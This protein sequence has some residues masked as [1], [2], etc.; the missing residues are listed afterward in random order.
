MAGFTQEEYSFQILG[1]KDTY[2]INQDR[3]LYL[4]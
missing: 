1:G 2:D 4:S 3:L